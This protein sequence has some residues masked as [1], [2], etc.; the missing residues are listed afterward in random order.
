M[1][2]TSMPSRVIPTDLLQIDVRRAIVACGAALLL[3]GCAELGGV[4]KKETQ[5]RGG[6]EATFLGRRKVNPA[7][8]ALPPGYRIEPVA[9]GF[10]FPTAVVFDD[11]NRPHVIESG[12][13]YGE[14]YAP[15]RLLRIE[16]NGRH[17]EI[18]R[19]G[20]QPWTGATFYRG[21][22]YVAQGGYP[23]RIVRITPDAKTS[24]VVDGLPS[25][26]D[27]FTNGPVVGPDGW[28]YFSQGAI[29][30][31]G[32]V[33]EDNALFGWLLVRPDLH[34][35][36]GQDIVLAGRNFKTGPIVPPLPVKSTTTGAFVPLGTPTRPGQVIQ[37]QVPA[38]A[39]VMR[40]RPEGGKTELVAWGIRNAFGLA[41]SPGGKLFATDTTYDSRGSRPIENAP[42]MLWQVRRG[43]WYGFPDFNAGVPLTDPRFK[44]EGKPQPQFL[45]AKHPNRP[46]KPAATFAPHSASHGLDFSRSDKFGHVGTAFVA[47]MGDFTPPT[48]VVQ[49]PAGYK[50]VRVN[51]ATG[52]V[53]D[54][55]WNK[56]AAPG[57][58]SKVGGGGLERPV[59][60][61]FDRTGEA[62]YVVDFGVV[63]TPLVPNPRK[64]TGVLWRITREL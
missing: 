4:V 35:I 45:L 51:T 3:T 37:G 34:D 31:S 39:A 57:P 54:F 50:V 48:G 11:A 64:K 38:T 22:F 46:P 59:D 28:L 52:S 40:V 33:G 56:A 47:Q 23:G 62:M 10:T 17:T 24:I 58:A 14:R 41:F 15:G 7:D 19:G 53:S 5:T 26:G 12:Y 20:N 6:A 27:H 42:D 44:P 30:N 29:T 16:A 55:A 1:P 13:A 21:A 61:Q 60:V 49:K 63:T 8:V 32:V 18:A 36:P 43:I 9:T 25:K 2:P